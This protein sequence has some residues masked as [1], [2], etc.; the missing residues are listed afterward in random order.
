MFSKQ[1]QQQQFIQI[2]NTQQIEKRHTQQDI[3]R[4]R[5]NWIFDVYLPDSFSPEMNV[6]TQT[7]QEDDISAAVLELSERNRNYR[8][9]VVEMWFVIIIY[10]WSQKLKIWK[11]WTEPIRIVICAI[12]AA[13]VVHALFT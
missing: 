13:N 6:Q 3:T 9:N 2:Q 5:I 7:S 12:R 10:I 11:I 4:Q 8:T 1:Q